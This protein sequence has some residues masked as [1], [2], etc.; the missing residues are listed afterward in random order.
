MKAKE[1]LRRWEVVMVEDQSGDCIY[2]IIDGGV[3]C[4]FV[5]PLSEISKTVQSGDRPYKIVL[6]MAVSAW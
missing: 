3:P 2:R 6:H 1:V 4:A 5:Q